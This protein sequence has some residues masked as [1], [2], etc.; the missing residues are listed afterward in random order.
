MP[1]V[2]RIVHKALH[3]E[4]ERVC[5]EVVRIYVQ[6]SRVEDY[7]ISLPEFEALQFKVLGDMAK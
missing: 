5:A 2:R 6:Q 1:L 7:L 4:V 3:I